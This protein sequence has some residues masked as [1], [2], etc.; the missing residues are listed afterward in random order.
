MVSVLAWSVVDRG[1]MSRS[2][3]TEKYKIGICCFSAKHV[4]LRS[5]SKDWFTRN[6]NSVFEWSDMSIRG[7]LFQWACT[8]IIKLSMLYKV[9]L[10][11]ISSNITYLVLAKIWL[12]IVHFVISNNHSL[13]TDV[14]YN[15]FIS[16]CRTR[17]WKAI[18]LSLEMCW[19]YRIINQKMTEITCVCRKIHSDQM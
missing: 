14:T 3:Q 15:I 18:Y 2:D 16:Y 9:D 6:Q 1:F 10:F 17:F 19:L 5:K 12:K 8:I 4:A 11:I 7:L 13:N